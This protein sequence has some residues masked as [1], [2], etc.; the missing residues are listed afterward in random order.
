MF[1]KIVIVL[2]MI[3]SFFCATMHQIKIAEGA[4]E[5]KLF[6]NDKVVSM[7]IKNNGE[8]KVDTATVVTKS[9]KCYMFQLQ[10]GK[11]I[12][13]KTCKDTEWKVN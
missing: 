4:D 1:S 12:A 8:E 9:G 6:K 7:A 3:A 13:W 10:K 5:Y 11:V 2:L